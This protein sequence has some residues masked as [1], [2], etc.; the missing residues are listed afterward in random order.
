MINWFL[1]FNENWGTSM[2]LLYAIVCN[3]DRILLQQAAMLQNHILTDF[4][5]LFSVK[6]EA[7]QYH[8]NFL[9][10]VCRDPKPIS[11]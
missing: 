8:L 2:F 10:T 7:C 3:T 1:H 9:R 6:M 5:L 11:R 4:P